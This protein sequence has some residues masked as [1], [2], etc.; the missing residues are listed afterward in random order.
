M[1]RAVALIVVVLI[2]LTCTSTAFAATTSNHYIIRFGA[3][4]SSP[5][6]G[7]VRVDFNVH[8]RDYMSSIGASSIVLYEN[9]SPV[10]TFSMYDPLYATDLYTT[11][12]DIFYGHVTYPANSGSTYSAVVSLFASDGSGSGFETCITGDVIIP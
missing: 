8:G 6:S 10:K 4:I 7:T 12:T 3:M 11:N 5:S 9:G 1:K 2:L